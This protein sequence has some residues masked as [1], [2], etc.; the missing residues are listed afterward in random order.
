MFTIPIIARTLGPD[1]FGTFMLSM[2][3]ATLMTIA[4]DFGMAPMLLRE[5]GLA[6]DNSL[7][8]INHALSAKFVATAFSISA[9]IALAT[10]LPADAQLPFFILLPAMLLDGFS[11]FFNAGLRAKSRYDIEAK[12]A[13]S[14]SLIN[15]VTI[16]L[17]AL[18][19][20]TL[21][22]I[23]VAY[24]IT[25]GVNVI[26]SYRNMT[27][28]IGKPCLVSWAES[29]K[30][31][32][33]STNYALDSAL[34]SAFGQ[35]DSLILNHW[36]GP[37]AV[38]IHQAGMRLFMAG[39]QAAAVLANVFLP[40]TAAAHAKN[41]RALGTE[42][43]RLQIAF[44]GIGCIIGLSMAYGAKNITKIMF[45]SDFTNLIALMPW[46]GLLFFLKFSTA[47]WGII[48]TATGHQRF[49]TV[50]NATQW[51]VVAITAAY[52]VP[53][54]GNIG[55]LISLITGTITLYIIYILKATGSIKS[56]LLLT[57]LVST[58]SVSF[59]PATIRS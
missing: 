38:G 40:R 1:Q 56:R 25:R 24:C 16:S 44:V 51:L 2:S 48:L 35:V 8:F 39:T 21:L 55:W 47:A 57:L 27:S 31:L 30:H 9:S 58:I 53:G 14:A 6:P 15:V 59:L 20:Q 49:R 3:L 5:I 52:S 33:K 11:E 43:F 13:L 50:A 17:T 19:A 22:S 42:T 4:S 32:G 29:I 12:C 7:A 10:I 18:I 36:L 54:A 26:M 41:P 37:A 23:S 28:I 46:F 34:S 45:G